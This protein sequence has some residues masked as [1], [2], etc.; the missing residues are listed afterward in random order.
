MIVA[1]DAMQSHGMLHWLLRP[2]HVLH[3]QGHDLSIILK[4]GLI[5]GIIVVHHGKFRQAR[6]ISTAHGSVST[7]AHIFSTGRIKGHF[8]IV[9][10]DKDTFPRARARQLFTLT[11][12]QRIHQS[13]NGHGISAIRNT[14]KGT[15]DAGRHL[16]HPKRCGHGASHC[17]FTRLALLCLER[18]RRYIW[19]AL[20]VGV[21]SSCL[22]DTFESFSICGS[23]YNHFSDW[24]QV[25]S[26][27]EFQIT[28]AS[29]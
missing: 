8:G 4:R 5:L 27:F 23:F 10:P 9:L 14:R 1:Q 19:C 3:C 6:G 16:L 28:P 29:E 26:D 21:Q 13:E 12:R 20:S 15:K 17:H 18:E 7:K 2:G 22:Y 11:R 25:P 24:R